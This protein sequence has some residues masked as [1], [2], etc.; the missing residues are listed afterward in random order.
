MS[1]AAP[2]ALTPQEAHDWLLHVVPLPKEANL[3][4]KVTLP[5]NRL[6]AFIDGPPDALYLQAMTA[7]RDSL[8]ARGTNPDAG[9]GDGGFDFRFVLGV[10]DAQGRCDGRLVGGADRLRTL[11][12]ADQGYIIA[13][14]DDQTIV[15]T[16]LTPVGV[17]YGIKT[18]WQLVEPTLRRENG[19]WVCDIPIGTIVDWPDLA[20]RGEWGGSADRD[21][22]WMSERKLN[23]CESHCRGLIVTPEGKG[24]ADFDKSLIERGAKCAV[25]VV[26]IITHMDQLNATGIF[27]VFPETLGKGDP[28]TWPDGGAEVRPACFSN[29]KTSRVLADWMVSLAEQPEVTDICVWLSENDVRCECDLCKQKGQFA[30]E[31]EAIAGGYALAKQVRPDIRLRVLLTQGSYEHNDQVIKVLPREIGITYYDGGR[32]Y[33]SSRNPMIYPL[34]EEYA[35]KGWLG[36]YP[37]LTASWRIVCPWSGPQF[38]RARMTEFVDKGLKCLCGYAT[39]DNRFYDFNVN[40]AAEWSWNAHGRDE[41]E[42]ALAYFTRKGLKDPGKAADWAAMLGP[43]GWDVYGARVPYW[44]FFD[45]I[46]QRLRTDDVPPLGKGPYEYIPDEAHFQAD[47][48]T[49]AGAMRL[50]QEVGEPALIAETQVIEGY[51]QMLREIRELSGAVGAKKQLSADEKQAVGAIMTRLDQST[52]QTVDGLRGWQQ[53]VAPDADVSRFDDTVAVTEG[54]AAQI[55][56]WVAGLGVDDPGRPFR[57]STV[58]G[59]KAEDFAQDSEIRKRWDITAR[60]SGPGRHQVKFV[61]K[62]GWYGLAIHRAALMAA[63]KLDPGKLTLVCEDKHEGEASYSN[64]ANTYTLDVPN[65]DPNLLYFVVADIRGMPKDSPPEKQGCE[66]EAWWWKQ[67]P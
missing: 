13:Q 42:F 19:V 17:C 21:I 37:Q 16:G 38:I 46:S 65:P 45:A 4:S 58:G 15:V 43:V 35:K 66:G 6:Q 32:T 7:I 20:E 34:L 36:C 33:D 62:A 10:L 49:C 63:A 30:L 14:A 57:T 24:A 9:G 12:N 44:W 3:H 23:L 5:A 27:R 28:K 61:Y 59:W 67:R 29:P 39:P 26:P 2:V 25:K 51:L 18:L 31:A 52:R 8:V 11:P 50:A 22:E 41:R 56:D 60:F 54:T 1:A 53:T 40:A 55:G 64:K 47:L 48:D